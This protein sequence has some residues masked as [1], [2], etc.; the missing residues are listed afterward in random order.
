VPPFPLFRRAA[1]FA[2]ALALAACGRPG[3]PPGVAAACAALPPP[4][5]A[6]D[7]PVEAEA[8]DQWLFSAA[9]LRAVNAERCRRGLTPLASDPALERAAAY[10]SGDM[11]VHGFF[12]HDSPVEGRRTP[13]ERVEQAGAGYARIAENIAR[14]SLYAFDGR[15]FYVRD[16]AACVFSFTPDGP[17]VP[18]RSYAGAAARLLENWLDSPGHRRNILD[19]AMTHHGAGAAVR[20]EPASCGELLVTQVLAG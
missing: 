6:F 16:P 1:L 7:R 12:G 11:V 17:P 19:P 15:H 10:H 8:I 9:L 18:R 13:R 5:H 3:P 4:D 14:T 2:A 20:A